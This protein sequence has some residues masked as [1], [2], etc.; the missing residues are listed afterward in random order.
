MK[1]LELA[2]LALVPLLALACG[3][4]RPQADAGV[5]TDGGPRDAGPRHDGGWVDGGARRDAGPWDAGPD[6][7]LQGTVLEQVAVRWDETLELCSRWMEEQSLEEELGAKVHFSLAPRTIPSLGRAHLLFGDPG[8]KVRR[9]AFSDGQ[10]RV[11]ALEPGRSLEDWRL[12]RRSGVTSLSA[13]VAHDLGEAGVLLENY[14]LARDEGAAQVPVEIGDEWGEVYFSYRAPGRSQPVILERC[15]GARDL[16]Q[17]VEVL[18]AQ[19]PGGGRAVTVTRFFNTQETVAGSYPVHLSSAVVKLSDRPWEAF[20]VHGFWAQTYAARHHNWFEHTRLDFSR[21]AGWYTLVFRRLEDGQAPLVRGALRRVEWWDVN[22]WDVEPQ[23]EIESLDPQTH[24]VSTE[25]LPV[26]GRLRR[27][28]RAAALALAQQRC[29]A[30]EVV[31]LGDL[32]GFEYA[33]HLLFCPRPGGGRDLSAVMPVAFLHEPAVIGELIEESAITVITEDGR[34]AHRVVVGDSQVVLTHDP[35]DPYWL[36][37]VRRGAE[38]LL[39]SLA[40]PGDLAPPYAP[41]ERLVQLNAEAGVRVEL[42]RRWAAQGTGESSLFA[43]ISLR[44]DF[45]GQSHFAEAWNLLAYENTHHNWLD[46]FEA[47]ADG[48]IL[49]WRTEFIPVYRSFVQATR[50]GSGEVVLPETEVAPQQ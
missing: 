42:V 37:S 48:L 24:Q 14:A 13:A 19:A 21:D 15:G 28:D 44:L 33:F 29:G 7:S 10:W 20:A 3:E 22:G 39:D 34:P 26:Q 47:E 11:E 9:S 25:R 4:D 12:E 40:F 18:V 27:V 30:P 8:G 36:L 32:F 49:A 38:R 31:T 2:G 50:R 6:D 46:R 43:P 5:S 23:L 17:A 41:E 16:R 35:A 1:K 45:D